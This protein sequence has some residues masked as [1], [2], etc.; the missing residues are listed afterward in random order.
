MDT[1]TSRE[2]KDNSVTY[3][4]QI[5]INWDGETVYQ[6][7]QAYDPKQVAKAWIKRRETE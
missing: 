5:R 3:T 2:R 4:A 6:E 7:S 1:I